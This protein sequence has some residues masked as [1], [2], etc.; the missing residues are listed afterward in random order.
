MSKQYGFY[1]DTERCIQ[2]WAC[3]V[4]CK[5]WNGIPAGTIARRKVHEVTTGT[6]PNVQRTF[7]SMSCMHCDEPACA[8]VCPAGA[9]SKRPDDGIVVVDKSKCIGCHY[10][11]FACPFSVPQYT[12]EGMDKCDMCLGNG[13]KPGEM[14]HCVAT[15]PTQA[16]QF[17]EMSELRAQ[18]SEEIAAGIAKA[19]DASFIVK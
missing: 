8:A 16:L 12:E 17:G 13:V 19:G 7:V 15:C 9:I 4:A 14:P 11:F 3:E 2:C 1:M 5:Q 10:C 6:F 18:R